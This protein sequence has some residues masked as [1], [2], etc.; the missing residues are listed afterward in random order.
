MENLMD[1]VGGTFR[2]DG[3]KKKVVDLRIIRESGH[4]VGVFLERKV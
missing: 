4:K 1:S 3:E 2:W